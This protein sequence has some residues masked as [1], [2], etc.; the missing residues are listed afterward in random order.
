MKRYGTRT[1]SYFRLL[2]FDVEDKTER[3]AALNS[4]LKNLY[5]SIK[6]DDFS[7]GVVHWT[8]QLHGLLDLKFEMT[9]GLRAR[10]ARLYYSLALAPSLDS[11]FARMVDR[12][13]RL[14]FAF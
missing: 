1:F 5:T 10:L 4:I 8:R 2:P 3:D 13:T 14:A 7:S 6:A 9:R 12:L 11:Q